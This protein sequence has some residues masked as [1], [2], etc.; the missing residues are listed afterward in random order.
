MASNKSAAAW[1]L[2]TFDEKT[3]TLVLH[4]DSLKMKKTTTFGHGI[5][6]WCVLTTECLL[7]YSGN[8]DKEAD[9]GKMKVNILTK[10]PSSRGELTCILP[11]IGE[12]ISLVEGNEKK[13]RKYMEYKFIKSKTKEKI[14]FLHQIPR[15][16]YAF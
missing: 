1:Q 4:E 2:P 12:N 13:K 14:L 9:P 6:K 15:T 3:K 10:G 5:I 16:L 11:L 8:E 7:F